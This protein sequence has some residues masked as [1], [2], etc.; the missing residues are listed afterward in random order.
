M[1]LRYSGFEGIFFSENMNSEDER[2]LFGLHILVFNN[3]KKKKGEVV[4][5]VY[6]HFR[7]MIK[8]REAF[9]WLKEISYYAV[10]G[11]YNFQ[12]YK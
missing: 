2:N 8:Y 3:I 6:I 9:L 10:S 1:C 4:Y 5:I 12:C 11:I 7:K